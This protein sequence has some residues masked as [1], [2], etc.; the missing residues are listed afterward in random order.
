MSLIITSS[1]QDRYEDE[2][3]GVELPYSYQNYLSHPMTIPPHSEVAV[4]SVKCS[5]SPYFRF[6]DN[7]RR[8]YLMNGKDAVNGEDITLKNPTTML[9][10]I[11]PD[12]VYDTKR[13]AVAVRDAINENWGRAHPDLL[14]AS[15]VRKETANVFAG[16]T[17]K[18]DQKEAVDIVDYANNVAF[19]PRPLLN[20]SQQE[21]KT[22]PW[23]L[24]GLSFYKTLL[25]TESALADIQT[26]D[27]VPDWWNSGTS[28]ITA[29]DGSL[30]AGTSGDAYIGGI[31]PSA[32]VSHQNGTLVFDVSGAID[33]NETGWI[34]GLTRP[35][36]C[37]SNL[38]AEQSYDGGDAKFK[39]YG[40]GG[41]TSIMPPWATEDRQALGDAWQWGDYTVRSVGTQAD[42]G[43]WG[44]FKLRIYYFGY[45]KGVTAGGLKMC[46]VKYWENTTTEYPA[47]AG[48]SA[49][50]PYDLALDANTLTTLQ[51]NVINEEVNVTGTFNGIVTTILRTT[52]ANSDVA[53][54]FPN[55][56]NP[57]RNFLY[58]KVMLQNKITGTSPTIQITAC[59]VRTDMGTSGIVKDVAWGYGGELY[60]RNQTTWGQDLDERIF[61]DPSCA[62]LPVQLDGNNFLDWVPTFVLHKTDH[63]LPS[64]LTEP[65]PNCDALLG[66]D[67]TDILRTSDGTAVASATEYSTTWGS[68]STPTL[69]AEHSVF[70]RCP[71]LT[72]ESQNF[73][74]GSMSKILYHLPQFDQSGRSTGSLFFEPSEKTYLKLGNS[75]PLT[76][77]QLAIDIVDKN[78]NYATEMDGNTVVVLHIR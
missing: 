41:M 12:G 16:F 14:V 32:P 51:F 76:I 26:A 1:K 21:L 4:Q 37:G 40:T 27:F 73:G 29:V 20:E 10:C 71:T 34:V 19:L 60:S 64:Y 9:E 28:T 42:D 33:A 43:S 11:I 67:G 58:P 66:F 38:P 44:D 46:E 61:S 59:G 50:E 25:N 57:M 35:L 36:A 6:D 62:I 3:M 23:G 68:V 24:N 48:V 75:E 8:F 54:T 77:N 69:P 39:V 49:T 15:V 74:K 22:G 52:G 53:N 72:Q 17:I 30:N 13:M 56:G 70:V 78:E 5:R 31:F 65:P 18:L 55:A 63:I 47:L 45:P 7:N 2:A